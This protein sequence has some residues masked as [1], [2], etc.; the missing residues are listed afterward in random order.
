MADEGQ[1]PKLLS[2]THRRFHTPHISILLN[3]ALVL[4]MTLSGTFIQAVTISTVARL[5]AY[6]A[7]CAALPVLRR[8]QDVPAALFTVRF[9]PAVAVAA[10][11]LAGWLLSHSTTREARDAAIVAV[12][13]LLLFGG[14]RW[15]R[16]SRQVS[17]EV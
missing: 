1:L 11:A 14:Y 12:F 7:T 9:G 5:I 16:R 15:V 6:A 17:V 3:G 10:L 2:A 13:G 4:V 8:R